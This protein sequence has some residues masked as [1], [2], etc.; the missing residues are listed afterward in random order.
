MTIRQCSIIFLAACLSAGSTSSGPL[1]F[2]GELAIQHIAKQIAFGPREPRN[3]LAKKN[4][5]SYLQQTLAPLADDISIQHFQAY[6]LEG[7]NLWASFQGP[8]HGDK[9][10]ERIMLAAHWDT[11][12]WADQDSDPALRRSAVIGANDGGSGVA[13]LLEM[14]R[15]LAYR[16]A[17]V[18]VDLVFF[19]LE[20]MG[21]IGNRPFSIGAQQF[22]A[23]NPKYR[24]SAG[25]VVDMVCDKNL[26]IPREQ[27]SD[28]RA[29]ALMDKLWSIA[30]TQ[31]ARAFKDRRGGFISDD[32]LPF[33]E[34]GIP[35][36]D[37]IHYPFPDYWHTT[38][39]T[40]D[41]CSARSLQQ[42]GNLLTDFIYTY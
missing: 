3:Q 19:D 33:L 25:V 10:S 9:P 30:K 22:I 23:A 11:R 7:A 17:P 5:L 2:D 13:L 1:L 12:P 18:T 27:Y 28:T 8:T 16:P 29:G 37:L 39:D 32:H 35:V 26:S 6:Q 42:V 20:D 14:A 21:G 31:Q 40:L 38:E 41:K 36:V 4:T 15:I 34:A 24:P